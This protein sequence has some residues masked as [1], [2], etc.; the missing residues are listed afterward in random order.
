MINIIPKLFG[1]TG[2]RRTLGQAT[3]WAL[4]S[5]CLLVTSLVSISV[6]EGVK[7]QS[8]SSVQIWARR[9]ASGNM[10]FGLRVN[11]SDIALNSRYLLYESVALGRFYHSEAQL[12]GASG[13]RAV[14]E[15][16]ARKLASGNVEFGLRVGGSRV[17]VP[18]AR[19]FPYNAAPVGQVNL[20]STFSTAGQGYSL[21]GEYGQE[22]LN[23]TVV[24][25]PRDDSTTS[26][27]DESKYGFNVGLARDCE[28]LLAVKRSLNRG[29]TVESRELSSWTTGRSISSWGS[30]VT[31]AKITANGRVM[32][33]V[34][35]LEISD[36]STLSG[37][38]PPEIGGLSELTTLSLG[39]G[40]EITGEIPPEIGNLRK[41]EKLSLQGL[42]LSGWIP[43]T[44]GSLVNLNE[45]KITGTVSSSDP[46]RG[47]TGPIP[48]LS[49]LSK[50]TRLDL[51]EN[52]LSG[53]IPSWFTVTNLPVL[54]HLYLDR[55]DLSGNIPWTVGKLSK[56]EFLHL[57]WNRLDGSIPAAD[58]DWAALRN[59]YLN[60]NQLSGQIPA[61]LAV[62]SLQAIEVRKNN[63][64]GPIP[65]QFAGHPNL[66]QAA[67]RGAS[68]PWFGSRL[69]SPPPAGD[70]P[71]LTCSPAGLR[72]FGT[73]TLFIVHVHG[74]PDC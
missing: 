53:A 14:V 2:S 49:E 17:W 67:F 32:N 1:S 20:S 10:E 71:G 34:T 26:D 3:L 27:V 28:A 72:P 55:N 60:D 64:S 70:N 45:L 12:V 46:N 25:L 6:G 18:R 19:Y 52:K 15:V 54:S 44:I 50:L 38:I 43:S 4:L 5:V 37:V 41:L 57:Q 8:G 7:A 33:R 35:E 24:P 59:L 63:L 29:N 9:L 23:G 48:D 30:K 40:D 69:T 11:G 74:L 42:A 56:L 61:E 66:N 39:S 73:P 13:S 51:G 58:G 21:S 16:R 22:C 62:S 65:S 47:I 31:L 68:R 36:A